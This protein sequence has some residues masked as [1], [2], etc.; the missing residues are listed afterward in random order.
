MKKFFIN[1]DFTIARE[2]G[3]S[4]KQIGKII[5]EKLKIPFYYKE[6]TALATQ[7]SGFDKEYIS[8]L[9]ENAPKI[10]YNLYLST[11][12]VQQA[13]VAQD[14]VIKKIAD[15]GSCVIVGRAADYVLRDYEDLLRIFIYAPEEYK[16]RQVMKIYGDDYD[17][18]KTNV[19]HSDNARAKYYKNVS[20]QDWGD[21]HNYDICI[22]SSIGIEE[23]AN[24][25]CDYVKNKRKTT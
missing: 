18:A 10:L 4:G 21:R 1:F 9:N 25:I 16:I 23:T 13:I 15:N 22:D 24:L 11:N 5:A 12:V 20:N 7:E 14:Q 6:M 19:S 2:H 8:E 17:T 3:T